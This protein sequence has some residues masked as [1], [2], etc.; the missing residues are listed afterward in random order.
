MSTAG[1][2]SGGDYAESSDGLAD[3]AFVLAAAI[4]AMLIVLVIL[5]FAFNALIDICI[6]REPDRPLREVADLW[7]KLASF[8]RSLSLYS[9]HS[10]E[11]ERGASSQSHDTVTFELPLARNQSAN[12]RRIYEPEVPS[13]PLENILTCRTL[14]DVEDPLLQHTSR[15]HSRRKAGS[16]SADDAHDDTESHNDDAHSVASEFGAETSANICSICLQSYR[17]NDRIA[18]APCGHVFHVSCIQ[19]WLEGR[20]SDCPNCRTL[21]V[22]SCEM[23]IQSGMVQTQTLSMTARRMP[24]QVQQR[25]QSTALQEDAAALA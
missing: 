6:L 8:S 2:P 12:R 17:I 5:R 13:V 1:V 21:I 3:K 20:G 7:Y 25:M 10:V 11:N 19:A 24:E 22:T 9:T 4:I 14:N 23:H 18:T 15:A 16:N